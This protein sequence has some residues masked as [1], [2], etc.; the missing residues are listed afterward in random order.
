MGLFDFLHRKKETVG[1]KKQAV[2][3]YVLIDVNNNN[4]SSANFIAFDL[5]TTG[6]SPENDRIVEIAAI[7]FE[8]GKATKSFSSLVHSVDNISAAA[9]RVNHISA[10][11]L[12]DAPSESDVFRRFIEFVGDAI[13]RKTCLVAHNARFDMSF[14]CNTLKRIGYSAEFNCVDTLSLAKERLTLSSF[15]Q[16]KIAEYYGIEVVNAHR[17][18]NDA[19][20]CGS[21]LLKLLNEE[22]KVA[23]T[24]KSFSTEQTASF[25]INGIKA[26]VTI[27]GVDNRTL[28]ERYGEEQVK[29]W[30]KKEERPTQEIMEICASIQKILMDAGRETGYVR[31]HNSGNT[32]RCTVYYDFLAFICGKKG[33]YLVINKSFAKNDNYVACAKKDLN[34][35]STYC[36]NNLGEFVRVPISCFEDISKYTDYI[37]LSFDKTSE[38]LEKDVKYLNENLAMHLSHYTEIDGNEI[39]GFIES[40]KNRVD[41]LKEYEIQMAIAEAEKQAIKEEKKKVKEAAETKKKQT[42]AIP[43]RKI[44]QMDDEGNV[45]NEY[46]S[47][48]EAINTTGINSKSIRDAAKG[49]QKHAGG[50][51]WK[52]IEAETLENTSD[53]K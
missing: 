17:A 27:T 13:E 1:I 40:Y 2:A 47:L 45:I 25:E 11:M 42:A 9:Q 35:V 6:L 4:F 22:K 38:L 20:V 39:E 10:D 19:F 15:K 44:L 23:N 34:H 16:S 12:R 3:D 5:E 32:V 33:S 28:A 29:E 31:F 52:Y 41:E 26:S 36:Y 50:F 18:E 30:F 8:A 46:N 14:L 24:R 53:N 48:Q 7:K 21:I 43:K 49:V 37:L 51:V